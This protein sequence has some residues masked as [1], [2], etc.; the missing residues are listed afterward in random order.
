MPG[1]QLTEKQRRHLRGLAHGLDPVVRVGQQGLTEAVIAETERALADH[2]LVKVKV[3]GADRD[4]RDA[5]LAGL[6]QRT[7]SSLV[8]RIGHVGVLYRRHAELPRILLP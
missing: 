6:A 1:M 2:E 5:L 4:S 7:A 3:Q 8:Q